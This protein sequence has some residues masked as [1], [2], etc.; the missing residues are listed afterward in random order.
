M[1][2]E[3]TRKDRGLYVG[4]NVIPCIGICPETSRVYVFAP[5]AQAIRWRG[6]VYVVART[7]E[8]LA[9]LIEEEEAVEALSTHS[10]D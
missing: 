9:E 6:R 5:T 8:L 10:T 4:G 2:E 7:S 1:D 3:S